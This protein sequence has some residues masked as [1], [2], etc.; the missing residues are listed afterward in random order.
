MKKEQNK[1][2][3]PIPLRFSAASVLASVPDLDEMDAE[4]LK[5]YYGELESVLERL[6][7]AEPKNEN[8]EAYETWALEHEDLEDLMDE[9]LDRI[10]DLA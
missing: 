4:G 9:I 5:N 6:D 1:T 2:A 8:S 3:G 10:E 7:G